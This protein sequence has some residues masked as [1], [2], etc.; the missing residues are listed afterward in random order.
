MD[1]S[2]ITILAASFGSG[3]ALGIATLLITVFTMIPASF[4]MNRFI[5]HNW[6]MRAVLGW[7]A[8]TFSLVSFII[9]I[10][11]RVMGGLKKAW[12][13]GL[14][15]LFMTTGPT[16]EPT[17]W[18]AFPLKIFSMFIHPLLM[19]YDGDNDKQGY[20]QTIEHMLVPE[21]SGG[22]MMDLEKNG[23]TVTK[24]L[25]YGAVYEPFFEQAREVAEISGHKEWSEAIE[26]LASSGVG[27]IV[28]SPVRAAESSTG[29]GTTS[30][31]TSGATSGTTS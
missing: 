25:Y 29:S 22:V 8:G 16:P 11:M 4:V 19:R 1:S 6:M 21:N 20:A 18:F 17:G 31:A 10:V 12:Y 13:F 15:P 7:I 5:Y 2:T 27:E 26:T 28:F 30:G 24:K 14:F 9:M 3:M 23:K